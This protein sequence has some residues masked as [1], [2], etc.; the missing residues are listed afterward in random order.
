[1][2]WWRGTGI[3]EEFK[4]V[5][6]KRSFGCIYFDLLV[7]AIIFLKFPIVLRP[8]Q[9][10]SLNASRMRIARL[11]SAIGEVLDGAPGYEVAGVD[12]LGEGRD[13]RVVAPGLLGREDRRVAEYLEHRTGNRFHQRLG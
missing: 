7:I 3:I 2:S 1:M 5:L 4:F 8:N 6:P 12:V 13:H 9:A 10:Q 11:G